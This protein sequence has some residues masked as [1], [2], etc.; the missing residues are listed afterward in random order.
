MGYFEGRLRQVQPG[1]LSAEHMSRLPRHFVYRVG[2]N[3]GGLWAG[4]LHMTR[5]DPNDPLA[6]C[7]ARSEAEIVVRRLSVRF[8]DPNW[9]LEMGKSLSVARAGLHKGTGK[10]S[11]MSGGDV[12]ITQFSLSVGVH[13]GVTFLRQMLEEWPLRQDPQDPQLFVTEPGDRRLRVLKDKSCAVVM[14]L[15]GAVRFDLTSAQLVPVR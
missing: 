3:V 4:T 5:G 8:P 10:A 12:Q 11:A 2:E 15:V 13:T 14:D 9:M 6:D 7:H 1:S